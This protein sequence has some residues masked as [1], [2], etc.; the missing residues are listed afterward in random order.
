ML[1]EEKKE[2]NNRVNINPLVYMKIY[3]NKHRSESHLV[4]RIKN[5]FI[6]D[7]GNWRWQT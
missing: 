1:N 2:Y 6:V 3:K 7:L 5:S 4:G